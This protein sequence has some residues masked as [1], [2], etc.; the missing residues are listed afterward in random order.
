MPLKIATLEQSQATDQEDPI[1]EKLAEMTEKGLEF[2][3]VFAENRIV[4][5]Y[6][7]I[8]PLKAESGV[9]LRDYQKEG[10]NWMA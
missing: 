4:S 10:I 5:E 1:S 9:K 2:L 3:A 6:E 8:V 7:I